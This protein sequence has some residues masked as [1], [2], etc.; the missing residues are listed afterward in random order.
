MF[1]FCIRKTEKSPKEYKKPQKH[2]NGEQSTGENTNCMGKKNQDLL[3]HTKHFATKNCDKETEKEKVE[4]D[5]QIK[6]K[7][8]TQK[9]P[10]H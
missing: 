5:D 1:F 8:K 7:T 2:T 6:G 10:L 3:K 9:K 4:N